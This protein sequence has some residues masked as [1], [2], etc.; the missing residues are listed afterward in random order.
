M[1][2]NPQVEKFLNDPMNESMLDDIKEGLTYA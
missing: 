1:M 2:Q